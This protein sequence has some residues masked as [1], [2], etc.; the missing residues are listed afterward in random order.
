MMI[1]RVNVGRISF[2]HG[3]LRLA[4]GQPGFGIEEIGNSS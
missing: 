1:G 3:E 4:Y 2:W